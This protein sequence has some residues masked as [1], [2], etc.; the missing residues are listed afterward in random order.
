MTN[1]SNMLSLE[2]NTLFLEDLLKSFLILL[3]SQ[4]VVGIGVGS[5]IGE[6]VS[7]NS[8]SLELA[9]EIIHGV[10]HLTSH[11]TLGVEG[12]EI[13]ILRISVKAE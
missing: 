4:Q 7:N 11:F 10:K 6:W 5:L 3:L 8:S 1:N 13:S 12:W 9:S 2:G